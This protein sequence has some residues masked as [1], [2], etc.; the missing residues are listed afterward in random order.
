MGDSSSPKP[1]GFSPKVDDYAI[2]NYFDMDRPAGFAPFADPVRQRQPERLIRVHERLLAT[3]VLELPHPLLAG[4]ATRARSSLQLNM[5]NFVFFSAHDGSSRWILLQ[6][7][8]FIDAIVV[9]GKLLYVSNMQKPAIRA[10]FALLLRNHR[11]LDGFFDKSD[12]FS[13]FLVSQKTPYHFFYDILKN[14]A[15]LAPATA[16]AGKSIRYRPDQLYFPVEALTPAVDH[17]DVRPGELLI[18]PT[19]VGQNALNAIGRRYTEWPRF[20]E[21]EEPLGADA[22]YVGMQM[23]AMEE[24]IFAYALA[25]KANLQETSGF[26]LWISV[27]DA[28]RSWIEQEGGF[29]ELIAALSLLV[30]EL[31]VLF[32]GMTAPVGGA[33]AIDTGSDVAVFEA[34]RSRVPAQVRCLSMTGMGYAE[35]VRLGSRVD[36]FLSDAGSA[37]LVPLRFCR[38]PGVLFS[39]G[40]INSF[41]DRYGSDV[42]FIDRSLVMVPP[43][44]MEKAAQFRSFHMY[45]KDVLE[46][47]LGL[48]PGLEAAAG[49]VPASAEERQEFFSCAAGGSA[50]PNA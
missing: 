34:I 16:E 28:K 42:R 47:A 33:H 9:P 32:D 1:S 13:G 8:N 35:K 43:A 41:P 21:T 36:L 20:T 4:V 18:Y 31:T 5:I 27:C 39:N 30:G 44:E 7:T 22:R 12:P 15:Q 14:L 24:R 25:D 48:L 45:W 6:L 38:K 10:C 17:G 29:V 26:V 40:W 37:A 19:T 11:I 50:M 2:W 49:F 46:A 3:D 23:R